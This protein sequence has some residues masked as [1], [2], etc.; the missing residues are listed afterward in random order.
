MR[1]DRLLSIILLLQTH[2]CLPAHRLATELEVSERTIYR[3]IE[4]LSFAGVPI[5][6]RLGPHGGVCLDENYRGMLAGVSREEIHSLLVSTGAGPLKDLGLSK[7]AGDLLL[8]L[9]ASLPSSKR[10]EVEWVRQRVYI[11]SVGWFNTIE[12]SPYL[13]LIQKAVWEDQEIVFTYQRPDGLPTQRPLKPYALVAKANKWYLVGE[14]TDGQI[15]T[16]RVARILDLKLN[17]RAFERMPGFDLITYWTEQTAAFESQIDEG[18]KPCTAVVRVSR[19]ALRTF[20]SDLAGRFQRLEM[21]DPQGWIHLRITFPSMGDAWSHVLSFGEEVE[22]IEPEALRTAVI[23]TASKVL[24][25]Y[26][27]DASHDRNPH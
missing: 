7:A 27:D 20:A 5:Y 13:P 12:T 6:T 4:A 2:S 19:Q 16:F 26:T 1:A 22:A 17:N 18:S 25:I 10:A 23:Q 21:D 15:R 8:K 9:V 3:D 11:D 24:S 14:Q